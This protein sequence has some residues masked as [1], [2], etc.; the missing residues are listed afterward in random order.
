M[1]EKGKTSKV[2]TL[3]IKSNQIGKLL[4][5]PLP[6]PNILKTCIPMF[7][8]GKT[9]SLFPLNLNGR[10]MHIFLAAMYFVLLLFLQGVLFK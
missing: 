6:N 4:E 5:C 10:K 8:C 3:L 9:E 7:E 2:S 1:E